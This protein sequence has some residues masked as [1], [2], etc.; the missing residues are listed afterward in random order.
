MKRVRYVVRLLWFTLRAL[1]RPS[2]IESLV[3]AGNLIS[4]IQ[5]FDV[6]LKRVKSDPAAR[7]LIQERYA[8]GQPSQS[9]LL[10][11]PVGSFGHE[12]AQMSIEQDL[13]R[14]P[15]PVPFDCSERV[16]LRERRREIHDYLHLVL[17]YDNSLTGEACLNTFLAAQS[18]MPMT[19]LIPIGVTLRTL[20]TD[21]SGLGQ[22]LDDLN[23]AWD[24]GKR[25][26]SPFGVRW[27][28]CLD[29][30]LVEAVEI[31]GPKSN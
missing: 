23:N 8:P 4:E 22:L 31:L 7:Q 6:A 10:A 11:L 25:C 5:A 29:L 20:V 28:D 9:T 13:A 16:Y 12:F 3:K 30:P 19:V 24:R 15:Y 27:E 26:P 1:H 18:A 14:Y 21:P 17:R 2:D